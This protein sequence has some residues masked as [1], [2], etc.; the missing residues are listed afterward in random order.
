MTN[1]VGSGPLLQHGD[2]PPA[3]NDARVAKP[4][5]VSP[6]HSQEITNSH[7]KRQSAAND[8]P[9]ETRIRVLQ[10]KLHIPDF[11]QGPTFDTA[12]DKLGRKLVQAKGH[13]P[14]SDR[15]I[16][17]RIAQLESQRATHNDTFAGRKT[18]HDIERLTYL[19]ELHGLTK[20]R[21]GLCEKSQNL[22]AKMGDL[23]RKLTDPTLSQPEW[24]KTAGQYRSTAL[25][26]DRC[27]IQLKGVQEGAPAAAS[28]DIM[29]SILGRFGNPPKPVTAK[30]LRQQLSEMQKEFQAYAQSSGGTKNAAP[31][32]Q[33]MRNNLHTALSNVCGRGDM[34]HIP[35]VIPEI[36]KTIDGLGAGKTAPRR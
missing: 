15:M 26:I 27:S 16:D 6:G 4:A 36:F 12:V 31:Y 29:D 9:I 1:P 10:T 17:D 7:L 19:K 14:I 30:F 25:E 34:N 13:E 32:L 35:D 5:G 33:S 28:A 2:H 24:L 23:K 18:D 11:H 3:A 21:N 8:A 22:S 20:T